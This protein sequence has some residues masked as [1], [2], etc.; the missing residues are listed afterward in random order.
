[1]IPTFFEQMPISCINLIAIIPLSV[2]PIVLLLVEYQKLWRNVLMTGSIPNCLKGLGFAK[3]ICIVALIAK[4]MAEIFFLYLQRHKLICNVTYTFRC[5]KVTCDIANNATNMTGKK[6][7]S[8][9]WLVGPPLGLSVS[10]STTVYF[11]SRTIIQARWVSLSLL[12]N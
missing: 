11:R 12:A 5:H 8:K 3:H 2:W 1:M 9:G 10:R 4:I 6:E 7:T